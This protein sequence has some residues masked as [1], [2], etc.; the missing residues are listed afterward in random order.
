MNLIRFVLQ[1]L[2]LKISLILVFTTN[3]SAQVNWDKYENNPIIDVGS[4]GTWDSRA[5]G[6]TSVIYHNGI[7]QA[8]LYGVDDMG[9]GRIGYASSND[10]IIW[11]KY[12]NNPVL[13]PGTQG[14][15]DDSHTDHACVLFIDGIYKM[16]YLGEDG[17]S[18]RI[19]YATSN[20]GITWEKYNGNPILDLGPEGSWDE[21][22]VM[23][24]SVFFDG[25]TYHMWYNGYGQDVQRTGYAFSDDGINWTKYA[26]NP[27]LTV[28]NPMAW[29]D[30]MLAL[31][32]VIYKDNEYKMW[33]TG[34][35]GPSEDERYFRIGYATSPDGISWTKN[36]NNPVLDVGEV[37]TWDSLGVVTS[38]V[39]FD[40]TLNIYKM[41]YGGL[42][43]SYG[44]TGYATSNLV[45][46]LNSESDMILPYNFELQQNY[47]N[48]FNP[49]TTITLNLSKPQKIKLTVY[50]VLGNEIEVLAEGFRKSG[51][52]SVEFFANNLSSGI[53][54]YVLQISPKISI[55]KK[56]VVMK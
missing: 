6:P 8:W 7:Y 51:T 41:W 9:T 38:A 36:G 28:G 45:S 11:S 31:M 46:G 1:K 17:T 54:F 26:G 52:Y 14:E 56:M 42:D 48:P 21:S 50:D 15:W 32:G 33:Y 27:V 43:G 16:W 35:D 47:P 40:T 2:V 25:S 13:V 53:Y 10:G 5:S 18:S 44:R 20:D 4:A 55:T 3:I 39:L 49:S 30:Y 34:A 29:D 19:G 24:P 37:G 22:E 12:E 23:H